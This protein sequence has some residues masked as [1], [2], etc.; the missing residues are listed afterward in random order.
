MENQEN[1]EIKLSRPKFLVPAFSIVFEK[2]DSEDSN[3]ISNASISSQTIHLAAER[4]QTM[5][6]VHRITHINRSRKKQSVQLSV[7]IKVVQ[8]FD[9]M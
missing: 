4:N 5:G 3:Q 6:Q 7:F 8:A 1:H 9:K 2:Y